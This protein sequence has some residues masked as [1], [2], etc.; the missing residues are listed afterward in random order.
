MSTVNENLSALKTNV[1]LPWLAPWFGERS[2]TRT[3]VQERDGMN[4]DNNNIQSVQSL[5]GVLER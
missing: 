2:R 4:N 1:H 3:A 5:G